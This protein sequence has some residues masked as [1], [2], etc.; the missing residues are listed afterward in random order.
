MLNV[1]AERGIYAAGVRRAISTTLM[2]FAS[3]LPLAEISI[4]ADSA[5]R[6]P[7]DNQHRI[8]IS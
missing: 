6:P 3:D 5:N 8:H 2:R 1:R 4:G 7:I